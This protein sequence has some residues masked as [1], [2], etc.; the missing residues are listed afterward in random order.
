MIGDSFEVAELRELAH[1]HRGELVDDGTF[2][3]LWQKVMMIVNQ[4]GQRS[5][6]FI[7]PWRSEH[8]ERSRIND[9]QLQATVCHQSGHRF[10][11]C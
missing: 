10:R 11:A 9:K 1:R 3:R 7:S 2:C 4:I 5:Y 6:H 8:G